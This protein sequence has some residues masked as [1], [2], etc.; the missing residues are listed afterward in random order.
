MC[1]TGASW[2]QWAGR[3]DKELKELLVLLNL[4]NIR[5]ENGRRR[6]KNWGE[7]WEVKLCDIME[8]KEEGKLKL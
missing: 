1:F 5:D 8:K 2:E 7:T 6:R 3:Q 4:Q